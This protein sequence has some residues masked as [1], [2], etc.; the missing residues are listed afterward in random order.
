MER[1]EEFIAAASVPFSFDPDEDIIASTK[2]LDPDRVIAAL[3]DDRVVG[4]AAS[5]RF[6]VTVPGG[7]RL[8]S[9]GVT[10][11]TVLPSHRRR[12]VLTAMMR[13]LLDDARDRGEPLSSLWASEAPIYGRY[14][15]G[16]AIET[17]TYR[18]AKARARFDPEHEPVN[19]VRIIDRDEALTRLPGFHDSLAWVGKF[20][21][22]VDHWRHWVMWD[23][24]FDR[25]GFTKRR[26]VVYDDGDGIGGYAFFRTKWT[27]TG[28]TVRVDELVAG[29]TG[30]ETSLYR[31]LFGIDLVD[32]IEFRRLRTDEP[33]R[34]MLHDTRAFRRHASEYMW[35]R[36]LDLPACLTARSYERSGTLVLDV[37]DG[38]APWNAGRWELAAGDGTATCVAS[39]A[40]ADVR[41][42]TAQLAALY[43]G[44]RSARTLASAG[45]IAGSPEAV[46]LLDDMFRIPVAPWSNEQY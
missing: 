42:D 13:R 17:V 28:G 8:M 40:E 16:Q 30:A 39:D 46:A 36:L 35:F 6:P 33:V 38:F 12:G 3:D 14:G 11:V 10:F 18:I 27:D 34:W 43:M 26:I 31:F 2:N 7:R 23:P 29:S 9:S 19:H 21:R 4:T 44:G 41:L 1:I 37:T 22:S 20:G 45:R 24:E 32:Q 25:D 5:L 15:Y